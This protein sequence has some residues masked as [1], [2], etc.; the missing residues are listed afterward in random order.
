MTKPQPGFET[1]RSEQTHPGMPSLVNTQHTTGLR[2]Q[3]TIASIVTTLALAFV[4]SSCAGY[5]L[6][7]GRPAALSH[8]KS[9]HV[10]MFEN[11]TLIPRGDVMATNS[12][13][14]AITIDGTY[15]IATADKADAVLRGTIESVSYDQVRSTRLDTLRSEEMENTVTL[16]WTLYDG[17]NPL[18]IL[19][20]G[21][22]KGSSRF[23]I[24]SNLQT[25]RSNALPD[26]LQRASKQVIGRLTDDY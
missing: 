12:V 14:D 3:V 9:I 5:R 23:A 2:S 6:Q 8:V 19:S 24:D 13:I 26:A 17:A 1:F 22:A 10:P 21:K 4:S 16:K 11:K 15:R 18:K 25:A 7:S 20:S